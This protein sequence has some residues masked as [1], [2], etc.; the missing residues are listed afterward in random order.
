MWEPAATVPAGAAAFLR[1]LGQA[2]DDAL[3]AWA[4][5]TLADPPAVWA[6]WLR[7]QGL[8]AYT[9]YRL[10]RAAALNRLPA[11]LAQAL[12]A[13][14]YRAAGDAELHTRELVAVL[15]A[16]A[17][18]G[19]M[20]ILF[21]GAALA[22]A[23][24]PDPA[25]RPMGDLDLWLGAD[26]MPRAQ[27]VLRDAGYLEH[28]QEARPPALLAGREGE[29]QWVGTRPEQGLIELHYGVFPGEWVYRAAAVD[30]AAVNSRARPV[31]IE[32]RPARTL[33]PED[34]V[35]Q[36]AVH[37]AVNHQMAYPGVRGLLDVRLLTAS[38][39]VEWETVARRALDWRVRT[40]VWQV[41]SLADEL[42]GLPQ[43]GGALAALQPSSLRRR[44]LAH[45]AS[46]DS[47]LRGRDLT[48][49]PARFI[50]QLLLAD[51]WRDAARL[52][53]RALW[54]ERAWLAARYGRSDW[55]TRR[56]HLLAAAR[57]R[58]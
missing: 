16:L 24:Y 34:A 15:D 40:A 22:Y 54:P 11:E 21:K 31:T 58:V 4:S 57:G 55:R 47:V 56:A 30:S 33:A 35:I 6:D 7:G 13:A 1:S 26:A 10:R 5:Q 8:A 37:F 39:R 51:R 29:L 14:Y 50:Y 41:L 53:F 38:S 42:L 17:G 25:C 3:I 12:Q 2:A 45:Y 19:V 27:A 32:D 46:I 20:P 28:V 49:G 43:A 18:A 48:G 52:V 44:L 9:C 23:A 36:L